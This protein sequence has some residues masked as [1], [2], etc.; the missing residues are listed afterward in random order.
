MASLVDEPQRISLVSSRYVQE[1]RNKQTKKGKKDKKKKKQRK[2]KGGLSN[3][4][5]IPTYVPTD[6][7]HLR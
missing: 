5:K 2:M 6:L 4:A 3:E 1:E 7:Y